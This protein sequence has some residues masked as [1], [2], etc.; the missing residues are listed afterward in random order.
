MRRFGTEKIKHMVEALGM[1]GDQAIRSKSLSRS[2]ESA[3][4]KV[5]GNNFDMR[6]S[7]LDYDNVVN[8]QRLIIYEKRNEILEQES[9]HESIK[10]TFKNTIAA[11]VENHIAP[12]GYLTENDK[13]EILEYVN[14]NFIKGKEIDINE[15]ADKKED[16]I[17]DYLMNEI[18]EDYEEKIK[19]AP[20]FEEF[21]KAIN[22]R[23]IDS[24]WVKHLNEME[25]LKDG[26]MLRGYGQINPLQAYTMDGFELFERL[27]N[28]IDNDVA[29]FLLKAEIEQNLERK[30][31]I[32][33]NAND[34]KEKVG[35]TVK[36]NKKIGRNDPCTCGSGKKY[37]QCCG[38]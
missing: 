14:T 26:I 31:V 17:I 15:I 21:E 16:E 32:Q 9:I 6:K 1:T 29:Q 36:K 24:L 3:Q 18:N 30:Q 7:L 38:K 28:K 8:E 5:E 4:K 13:K 37:K 33:G 19:D 20:H 22:L 10:E 11:L 23:V 2:I 27:L 35:H 34:G 12:E 25:H